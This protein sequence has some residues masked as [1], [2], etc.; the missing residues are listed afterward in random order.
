MERST[1]KRPFSESSNPLRRRRLDEPDRTTLSLVFEKASDKKQAIKTSDKRIAERQKNT[2]IQYLTDHSSA[3]TAE[4]A[5][6]LDVSV[7]RARSILSKL[8]EEDFVIA[9]GAN[10]NRK[11]RLKA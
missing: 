3:K 8:I 9:E 2:V 4:I 7:P 10:R 6:A 1:S 11:Y 5:E